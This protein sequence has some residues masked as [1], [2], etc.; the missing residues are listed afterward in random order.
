MAV[1]DPTYRYATQTWEADGVRTQYEIAFDGGYIRQ[2]D[3]VAFSVLVD[4]DTGLT[5]DRTI[6]ALTFLSEEVDPDTEWKT[7]T[8][9]I[10]PA[11]PAGRRVVIF[12]STE[13]S[14][15]LVNYTN[16][17]VLTEKNLDLANDQA[18]FG[19][20]EIMDGLANVG[21]TVEQTVG[22]VIDMNELIRE[23]YESVL[24][25]L[26]SGGII[27]VEPRTWVFVGDG[28][29]VDFPLLGADVDDAGFYDTYVSGLGVIPNTDYTILTSD[30]PEDTLI[31][32]ETP[33]GDGVV[34]F[35]VLRGYAKP[36]TGPAPIVS[37]AI[38]IYDTDLAA[39][40]ADEAIRWGLLRCN[41]VDGT[42]VA[43]KEINPLSATR[44]TTGDYFSFV[45]RGMAPVVVVPDSED[46]TINVPAG[47]LPQTRGFNCT[48]TATCEDADSNLWLLSG[49]LAQE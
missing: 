25:L 26:A 46:V 47:C 35:T 49:D 43:I 20:A 16:G 33:P 9:Q 8:V 32:F 6:H 29:T 19:I 23:L 44:L 22:V 36:Y 17:S 18:I 1:N 28:E 34:C 5:T 27:S 48:I 12:R 24:E 21:L 14:E 31:H 45:Q 40:F 15:G 39:F 2:S 10:T 4:E 42:D 37:L 41:N 38:P 13:K 11:V 3:V 30:T 7:A